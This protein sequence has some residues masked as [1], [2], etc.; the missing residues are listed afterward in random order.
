MSRFVCFCFIASIEPSSHFF[1]QDGSGWTP[2]MIA[3]S[4]KNAE[5]DAIVDLL[6][7]K[8]ADVNIKSVSG[9]VRH[10]LNSFD[11]ITPNVYVSHRTPFTSQLR[12]PI[13]QPSKP[14][15][16]INAVRVSKTDEASSHYTELPLLA[17]HLY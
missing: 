14:S 5:G 8:D 13:S 3:A 1:L 4:L 17:Q 10:Y 6:L 11:K 9:Q 16:P 2:L 12:R 15:S 7:R